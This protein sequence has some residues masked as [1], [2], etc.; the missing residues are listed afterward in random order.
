MYRTD[1][2]TYVLVTL[3]VHAHV[4]DQVGDQVENEVN[5][6]FF[7][8]LESLIAFANEVS[9]QANDQAVTLH[10]YNQNDKILFRQL[11]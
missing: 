5:N 7:N 8:E 10:R 9:D 4:S 1:E 3:L 2:Q 11:H 6:L